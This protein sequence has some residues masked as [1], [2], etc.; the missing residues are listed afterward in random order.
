[1]MS[2]NFGKFL[3]PLESLPIV[4]CFITLA[5]VVLSQN[6]C[7]PPPLQDHD[8]MQWQ[9]NVK[10]KRASKHLKR[11]KCLSRFKFKQLLSLNCKT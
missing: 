8:V 11:Q 3:T 5:L 7:M 2:R 6:P 9:T 1:M 4:K 10:E